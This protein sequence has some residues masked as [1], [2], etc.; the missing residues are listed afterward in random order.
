MDFKTIIIFTKYQNVGA[1]GSKTQ[2]KNGV[3]LPE[4]TEII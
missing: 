4:V 3:I 2:K 1:I